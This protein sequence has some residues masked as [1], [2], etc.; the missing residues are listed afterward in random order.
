MNKFSTRIS[1]TS[2]QDSVCCSKI[3]RMK[4]EINRHFMNID[5]CRNRKEINLSIRFPLILLCGENRLWR[6]SS[7]NTWRWLLPAAF[8]PVTL[9]SDYQPNQISCFFLGS[10]GYVVYISPDLLVIVSMINDTDIW[11]LCVSMLDLL[12]Q[13]KNNITSKITAILLFTFRLLTTR[14]F[15][16]FD[17]FSLLVMWFQLSSKVCLADPRGRKSSKKN[18]IVFSLSASH[19]T[20]PLDLL[21]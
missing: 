2:P 17:P 5:C 4:E 7:Q 9:L 12:D 6:N 16:L 21:W 15:R 18:P 3:L 8:S 14:K 10:F 11:T 19:E 1:H 13:Q 20:A